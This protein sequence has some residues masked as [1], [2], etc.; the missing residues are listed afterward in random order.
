MTTRRRSKGKPRRRRPYQRAVNRRPQQGKEDQSEKLEDLQDEI[1]A[2]KSK[3]GLHDDSMDAEDKPVVTESSTVDDADTEPEDTA[4]VDA[5]DDHEPD[6]E[7]EQL[8]DLEAHDDDD[9]L[10]ELD[11][12]TY[13]D[14]VGEDGSVLVDTEDSGAVR[15]LDSLVYYEIDG[16]INEKTGK[17]FNRM[18]LLQSPPRLV[19]RQHIS[20]DDDPDNDAMVTM[21]VNRQLAAHLAS[22]FESIRKTYDGEPLDK[23]KEPFSWKRVRDNFAKT[24]K[25]EPVKIVIGAVVAVIF[26]AAIIY[27]SIVA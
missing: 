24:W 9:D 7:S 26:I 20:G 5:T 15:V 4:P 1:N 6:L 10:D 17:P 23:K 12:S 8:E 25:Y 18:K 27:G 22:T 21:V 19:L 3:I 11:D 16:W 13:E 2:L 14:L